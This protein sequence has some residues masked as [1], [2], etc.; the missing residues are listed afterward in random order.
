MEESA[1]HQEW[2]LSKE[3]IQPL[4]SGRKAAKLATIA[5]P[6][7]PKKLAEERQEYEN[8]LRM[9]DG[10]D[11]LDPWYRYVNWLLLRSVVP[12]SYCIHFVGISPGLSKST[13][14][15]AKK[16][17][18]ISY[19]KAVSRASKTSKKPITTPGCAPFGWSTL[20]WAPSR[21]RC[22]A[23]CS[24]TA[25]APRDPRCSRPGPGTSSPPRRSRRP[26]PCSPR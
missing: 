16:A 10:P 24:P 2:E 15:E 22:S 5:Q 25:S 17:G 6:T 8:A 20:P 13:L 14:K 11:P 9:Y 1:S 21:W 23:S 7:D 4:R 19:W 12:Y 18:W 26:S 3:N